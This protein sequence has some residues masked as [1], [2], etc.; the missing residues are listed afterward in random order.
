MASRLIYDEQ[1][2][3]LEWAGSRIGGKGSFLPDSVAIGCEFDGE[4]RA[5]VVF[6]AFSQSDCDIHMAVD[7]HGRGVSRGFLAAVFAY[8]FVQ[9]G[10]R[11][12][13]GRVP[14]SCKEALA[15]DEA[16]GF[17]REG[18]HPQAAGDEAVISLGLLKQNC[19]FI[20]QE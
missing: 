5:V 20:N 7:K 3:L 12:V 1:D 17:V 8:P 4:I 13:T 9:L 11:R 18:Y 2:R 15:I 16:L 10:L 19:R 14:E 6:E